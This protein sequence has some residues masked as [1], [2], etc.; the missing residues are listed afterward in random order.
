MINASNNPFSCQPAVIGLNNQILELGTITRV[1]NTFTFSLGFKWEINSQIFQNTTTFDYTPLAATTGYKRIDIAVLNTNNEIEFLAGTESD[2]IALRPTIPV[3]NL[4]LTQWN[5]DGAT[6]EDSETPLLGSDFVKKTFAQPFSFTGTGEHATIPLDPLGREEIRLTNASLVSI[7]GFDLSLITGNPSAEVPYL[8]KRY[9]IRNLTG[10]DV[11]LL[12]DY[13]MPDIIFY[14]RD[15]EDVI[16]PNGHEIEIIYAGGAFAEGL[17]SWSVAAPSNAKRIYQFDTVAF[18]RFSFPANSNLVNFDTKYAIGYAQTTTDSG[19]TNFLT[20]LGQ[21]GNNATFHFIA[22]FDM[23]LIRNQS[24]GG[25][26]GSWQ[27]FDLRF[28]LG[29]FEPIYDGST[30]PYVT[31]TNITSLIDKNFPTLNGYVDM[32]EDIVGGLTIPKGAVCAFS[33]AHLRPFRV[34][35]YINTSLIFEEI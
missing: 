24:L 35:G 11:T 27:G 23:K 22:P 34:T 19:T 33:Y 16:I 14:S 8:G 17:R 28:C 26:S 18:Q 32:R 13:I 29:Y 5:I 15:G 9:R 20:W 4:L 2:T 7:G 12:N 30:A 6:I 31:K 10:V 1:T 25:Y 3:N 21:T